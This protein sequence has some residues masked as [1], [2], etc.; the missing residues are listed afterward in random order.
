MSCSCGTRDPYYCSRL[1]L[2]MPRASDAEIDEIS[3]GP[4]D[5]PCHDEPQEEG[6]E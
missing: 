4:C 2:R 6:D 1:R 5:C 3:G